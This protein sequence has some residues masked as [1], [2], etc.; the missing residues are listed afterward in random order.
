MLRAE[1]VDVSYGEGLALQGVSLE[2][3]PGTV[4]CLMGRN[5]VGKTT[6]LRTLAGVLRPRAGRVLLG[7]REITAWPTYRR[8]RAGI[9]YVPQGRGIFPTL[10]VRENL[11]LGL[12]AR[13]RAAP[14][15]I[16]EALAVFPNLRDLLRRPGGALSGGQQQQ[17][18]IARALVGRP[19]WLLLDEPTEGVQPSIVHEIEAV[20]AGI[21]ADGRTSVLLVEQYLDFAL[22]LADRYYLMERGTVVDAG[23]V[24]RMDRTRVREA[25]AL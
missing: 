18:A 12:E 21:A 6:L 19:R 2:V 11:L 7:E 4:V 23:P 13:G 14:E 9:G 10:T 17:L 1:A 22:R 20:I 25:L 16:A 15:A 5:G 24:D 8:A 3:P